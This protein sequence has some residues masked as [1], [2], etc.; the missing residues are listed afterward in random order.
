MARVKNKAFTLCD[1]MKTHTNITEFIFIFK[2]K[3]LSYITFSILFSIHFIN[4]ITK[5]WEFKYDVAV[6]IIVIITI[7]S[8]NSFN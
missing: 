5:L 1:Q 4:F 7:T 8:Y 3:K 6:N 2:K